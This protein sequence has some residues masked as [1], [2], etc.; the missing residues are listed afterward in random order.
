MAQ[1]KRPVGIVVEKLGITAR[2]L[3]KK[4]NITEST[5]SKW[6]ETG[7]NIPYKY[8]QRI[9]NLGKRKDIEIT[10]EDFFKV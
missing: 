2:E 9:V 5:V 8:H 3:A 7:G 4:L 10:A 1:E 6:K